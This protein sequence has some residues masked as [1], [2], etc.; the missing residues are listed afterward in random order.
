MR[1]MTTDCSSL[2]LK[3]FTTLVHFR[4]DCQDQTAPVIF[5]GKVRCYEENRKKEPTNLGLNLIKVES[6]ERHRVAHR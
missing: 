5:Y 4:V 2:F 1:L 3:L 6:A